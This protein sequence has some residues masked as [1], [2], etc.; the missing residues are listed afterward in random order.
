LQITFTTLSQSVSVLTPFV[1]DLLG[2]REFLWRAVFAHIR[3]RAVRFTDHLIGL[4][5]SVLF[6]LCLCC[7]GLPGLGGFALALG[8]DRTLSGARDHGAEKALA[9]GHEPYAFRRALIQRNGPGKSTL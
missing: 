8:F 2:F 3:N 9:A 7:S 4:S 1:G 5:A 6:G